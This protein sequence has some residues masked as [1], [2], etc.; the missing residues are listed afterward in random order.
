MQA[1]IENLG[2]DVTFGR[3]L[4]PSQ[5]ALLWKLLQN[6][7]PTSAVVSEMASCPDG[8]GMA[9][10]CLSVL[11]KG[12]VQ[13][14]P[15]KFLDLSDCIDLSPRKIFFL[16]NQLPKSVEGLTLGTSAVGPALSLLRRFL[17]GVGSPGEQ[18]N[19]GP[20]LQRLSLANCLVGPLEAC[21]IFSVLPAS[22]V[23]LNLTGNPL[24]TEGFRAL[25]KWISDGKAASLVHLDLEGTGLNDEYL[26]MLCG[27]VEG[28]SLKLE[29]LNLGLNGLQVGGVER[30][31]SVL[32]AA[33]LPEI[34]VL[35]L[36]ECGLLDEAIGRLADCLGRGVVRNLETLEL[37]GNDRCLGHCLGR[38][39]RS[40]RKDA[41]PH[42]RKLGL[43]GIKQL[44]AVDI[45]QAVRD[46]LDALSASECPPHLRVQ[47]PHLVLTSD[48]LSEKEVRALGAGKHPSL[49]TLRLE[50]QGE[51]LQMFFEEMVGATGPLH[52]KEMYLFLFPDSEEEDENAKGGLKLM[53][54]A[55]QMGRL[56]VVRQL[57]VD[58]VGESEGE[59]KTAFCTALGV[60][61]LPH[62]STLLLSGMLTD[63]AGTPFAQVIREGNLSGLRILGLNGNEVTGGKMETVMR[64][65]VESEEGMPLLSVLDLSDTRAG[66]GGSLGPF[67]MSEKLGGL[68][69]LDLCDSHLTDEALRGL[70]DAVRAGSLVKFCSL[71]FRRNS[72]VSK[73]AWGELVQAIVGREEGLPKLVSLDVSDTTA[74]E[75][76]G[77]IAAAL[78]SGKL[79]SLTDLYPRWFYIDDDEVEG[80]GGAIRAARFP[81]HVGH[82]S[83]YLDDEANI[84]VDGLITA[85]AESEKGLPACV[86]SLDLSGG[87]V[88]EEALALLAA[89]GGEGVG[90]LSDLGSLDLSSCQIDDGMLRQWGEVFSAHRCP[91]LETINLMDNRISVDGV[92]AF[93]DVLAPQSLPQLERLNLH[94]QEG[95]EGV[96][97]QRNFGSAVEALRHAAHREG[98]LQ[99]WTQAI[100]FIE[101]E[102]ETE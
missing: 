76:G 19:D 75:A 67:L 57:C 25:A 92:S 80:L 51:K 102:P 16:L 26:G 27:A 78:G 79:P 101:A 89:S 24:G 59:A 97:Q 81:P 53:G 12:K 6:V 90:K 84:N 83:F 72:D 28:K 61:K 48:L 85:I 98:K 21:V 22:I 100:E 65:V 23:H 33:S 20:S 99:M 34:R 15:L 54:E 31:C 47:L 8:Y 64:A 9:W 32:C 42:L 66:E 58:V 39:G 3:A 63:A 86:R 71:N 7:R 82:I 10:F 87:R 88:G 91:K 46:F 62:L 17:E 52:Y 41:V 4:E 95:M 18:G 74:I 38:L 5:E 55:I 1:G 70:T 14:V 13:G 43:E 93:F 40:L 30:L 68:S 73:E 44:G 50:V 36:K 45:G 60:V 56:S 37:G 94:G 49:D 69:E 35:I 96:E 77:V 29:T 11:K 2:E